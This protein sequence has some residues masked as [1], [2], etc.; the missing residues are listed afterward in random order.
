MPFTPRL[1]LVTA[2]SI[3]EARHLTKLIMEQHLAACVNILPAL[4]S[5]YFW[6]GQLETAPEV[7]MLIKSSAEKFESLCKLISLHHSYECPEVVALDP[8]E[9]APAYRR[10]W[11]ENSAP[12][13]A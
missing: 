12:P 5:H 6:K 8:R 4:E 11:E 1:V 9:I 10:W 3:E 7:L 13:E 2:P